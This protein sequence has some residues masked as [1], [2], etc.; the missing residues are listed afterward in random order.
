MRTEAA[1]YDERAARSGCAGRIKRR[2]ETLG[3]SPMESVTA[4]C[5]WR[6]AVNYSGGSGLARYA[7]FEEGTMRIALI[8][9]VIAAACCC[10][11]AS[12]QAGKSRRGN[13]PYT[14]ARSP[15]SPYL[16]LS[17]GNVGGVPAYYSWV[18]PRIEYEQRVQDVNRELQLLD[19]SL[20][21]Q[22]PYLRQQEARGI[23]PT[24][25]AA[26]YMNYSHFYQMPQTGPRR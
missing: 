15:I 24:N 14:P 2:E 13:Y 26:T 18:R 17:R 11:E 5:G 9:A 20:S 23:G 7:V 12:A 3:D 19:T 10:G 4:T 22:E 21:Q 16:Y 25:S 1:P 6:G 8:L